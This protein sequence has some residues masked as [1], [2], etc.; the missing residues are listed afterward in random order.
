MV[1]KLP[2][3]CSGG[4]FEYFL[5]SALIERGLFMELKGTEDGGI[6]AEYPF[7]LFT[8]LPDWVVFADLLGRIRKVNI[9]GQ[10]NINKKLHY[11]VVFLV[12]FSIT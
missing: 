5:F 10:S 4:L 2:T 8:Q 11:E 9:S 12:F 3:L 1:Y 6:S 7:L